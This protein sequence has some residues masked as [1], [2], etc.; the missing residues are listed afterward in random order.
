MVDTVLRQAVGSDYPIPAQ[1]VES[2]M[3]LEAGCGP[4]LTDDQANQIADVVNRVVNTE[5]A[6]GVHW[7]GMIVKAIAAAN[8]LRFV[9][10]AAGAGGS[11]SDVMVF[12]MTKATGTKAVVAILTGMWCTTVHQSKR[13]T[14]AASIAGNLVGADVLFT[15]NTFGLNNAELVGAFFE[16]LAGSLEKVYSLAGVDKVTALP[17]VQTA[18]QLYVPFL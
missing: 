10:R 9:V 7:N 17:A 16:D 11:V 14:T 6:V 18:S 5:S 1:E 15:T 3:A 2:W 12:R 8:D 4:T 13:A